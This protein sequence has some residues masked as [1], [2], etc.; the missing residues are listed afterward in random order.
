MLYPY[1]A[2]DQHVKPNIVL[3]FPDD[4]E[5]PNSKNT[6]GG[7]VSKL[8]QKCTSMNPRRS[9]EWENFGDNPFI[10]MVQKSQKI[11]SNY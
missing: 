8:F 7:R 10:K 2:F 5:Y 11:I 6:F 1:H 4:I 3:F 9:Q